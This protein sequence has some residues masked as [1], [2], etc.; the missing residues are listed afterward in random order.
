[1]PFD[2]SGLPGEAPLQPGR[3]LAGGNT[4]RTVVPSPASLASLSLPPE[5]SVYAPETKSLSEA[6]G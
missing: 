4:S 2:P 6:A 1:M 5:L 3:H